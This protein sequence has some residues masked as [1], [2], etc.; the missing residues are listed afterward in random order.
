MAESVAERPFAGL[1]RAIA[2]RRTELGLKRRGLAD[3]A[4]LSYPYISEIENGLKEPSYTALGRIADALELDRS[5]LLGLSE[6]IDEGSPA[7]QPWDAAS[8]DTRS[9]SLLLQ[10]VPAPPA[11]D[12]RRVSP[13]VQVDETEVTELVRTEIRRELDAWATYKLPDLIRR[14]L[15]RLAPDLLA[16]G[17]E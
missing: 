17:E 10:R 2:L 15:E 6:R 13:N 16:E 12:E 8:T 4:E 9:P 14:E 1:G 3:L 5:E 7:K 11:A